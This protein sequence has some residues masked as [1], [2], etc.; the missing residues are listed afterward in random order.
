MSRDFLC[1]SSLWI[2]PLLRICSAACFI[3]YAIWPNALTFL[4]IYYSLGKREYCVFFRCYITHSHRAVFFNS[5]LATLNGRD[6]LLEKLGDVVMSEF[7]TSYQFNTKSKG[8]DMEN[9]SK[10]EPSGFQMR[11]V[12]I[13]ELS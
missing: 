9:Y 5:L 13:L 3:T 8:K 7:S 11:K 1:L 12:G 4:G 2:S 6:A 10:R